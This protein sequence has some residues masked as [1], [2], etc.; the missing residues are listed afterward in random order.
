MSKTT[1]KPSQGR[2]DFLKLASTAAPAAI[3][4]V[5]MGGTEAEAAETGQKKSGLQDTAHT[6]AFYESARF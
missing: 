4:A 6:R 3:A 2:R 1:G 5:A